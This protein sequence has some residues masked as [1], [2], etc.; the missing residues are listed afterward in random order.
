MIG[1]LSTDQRGLSLLE[2]LISTVVLGIAVAGFLM[3]LST[4][5]TLS[6]TAVDENQLIYLAGLEFENLRAAGFE[7][8]PFLMTG[9]AGSLQD[10]PDY[11][12]NIAICQHYGGNTQP[13]ASGDLSTVSGEFSR[14]LAFDGRRA[15]F[16]SRW[17]APNNL[18][19]WVDTGGG[20]GAGGPGGGG[21]GGGGPGGGPGGG[22]DYAPDDYQYVY[23][24]FPEKT[25]IAR[26]LY[27]NRF[28]VTETMDVDVSPTDFDYLPHESNIWQRNF[29]FF[30][31]DKVLGN[32]E[33]L[34]P[35]REA[36]HIVETVKDQG[37]AS[38]GIRM[39]FDNAVEPM[40]VGLLG[41]RGIDTY[42][43]FDRNFHWPFVSEIEAY[44]FSK[45]TNYVDK[46]EMESGEFEYNNVIMY[47]TN[48]L[49]SGF[50]MGRRVYTQAAGDEEAV[51]SQADLVRVELGFFPSTNVNLNADW[52]RTGWWDERT[53]PLA[54]FETTFY[55][56]AP[57]RVDRLPSLNNFP[58]HLVYGDNE[59]LK[60]P[61]LVPG[62]SE[63]RGRFGVFDLESGGDIVTVEDKDANVYSEPTGGYGPAVWTPW[64]TGDTLVI[65]FTSN[66]SGS[67]YD[68]NYKGF[69][70]DQVEVRWVGV[71]STNP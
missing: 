27:D 59:D 4:S 49:G 61:F 41:V 56:D 63:I 58:T 7:D 71:D 10:V 5:A 35:W 43:D 8:I 69:S 24:S 32:G 42:S 33:I 62:A 57:T 66:S 19:A 22:G 67:T 18:L 28:N 29:E 44:G 39:I 68:L 30:W 21:P 3:A 16:N 14:D 70:I 36:T 11:F 55:R 25:K 47:F 31:S 23:C 65:H 20:P 51:E 34:D 15:N 37:Y 2:V 54:R 38:G 64:V 17:M 52:Q 46:V 12:R 48:Y 53:K 45:A 9:E 60:F 50:D 26:I 6:R 40:E 13:M 1:K